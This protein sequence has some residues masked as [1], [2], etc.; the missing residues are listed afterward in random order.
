MAEA[1]RRR[2]RSVQFDDGKIR[3]V[4]PKSYHALRWLDSLD[5]QQLG[6]ME[7]AA[8]ALLSGNEPNAETA[9]GARAAHGLP[10]GAAVVLDPDAA[11]AGPPV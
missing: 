3:G 10:G 8:A 5:A 11:R 9:A 7:A 1:A 4:Y 6:L 2:A